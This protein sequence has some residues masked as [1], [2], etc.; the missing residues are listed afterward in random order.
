MSPTLPQCVPVVIAEIFGDGGVRAFAATG[1]RPA[2]IGTDP[3]MQK[4]RIPSSVKVA[5]N[6]TWRDPW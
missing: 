4:P 3:R 1:S 2:A 6:F 5:D